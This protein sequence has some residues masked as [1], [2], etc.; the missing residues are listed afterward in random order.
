M[1]IEVMLP[2][3]DGNEEAKV[4]IV[5]ESGGG[6]AIGFEGHGTHDMKPECGFPV[7]IEFHKGEPRVYVWSDIRDSDVTHMIDLAMTREKY[8]VPEEADEPCPING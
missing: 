1:R 6:I 8:R 3:N 4:I 2:T 7:Y 5:R